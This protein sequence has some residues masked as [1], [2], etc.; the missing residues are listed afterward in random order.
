MT[1]LF[2]FAFSRN[3]FN[4]VFVNFYGCYDKHSLSV[5]IR[6]KKHNRSPPSCLPHFPL[7]ESPTSREP[8]VLKC[9]CKRSESQL[10]EREPGRLPFLSPFVLSEP[11]ADWYL[12]MWRADLTSSV[13]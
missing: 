6:L 5:S 3:H 2:L 4:E 1:L 10:W 12:T 9:E 8:G 11:S 13:H 7:L